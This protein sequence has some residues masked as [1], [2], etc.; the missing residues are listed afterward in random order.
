[1]KIVYRAANIPEADIVA[2]MLRSRGIEADVGG[3]YLQ[4]A[5]GAA[6]VHD[7]ARVLVSEAQYEEALAVVA[8]Y[9]DASPTPIRQEAKTP[10]KPFAALGAVYQTR[11]VLVVTAAVTYLVS[12][13][14]ANV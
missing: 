8:E 2:G 10:R 9:D 12:L 13:W 1:M 7:F 5:V 3:R 11:V 4:T 14:A 6:A